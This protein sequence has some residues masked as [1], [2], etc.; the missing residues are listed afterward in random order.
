[1]EELTF[2]EWLVEKGYVTEESQIIYE[3][4]A[5]EVDELYKI[6]EEETGHTLFY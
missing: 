1:M 6:W 5:Y 2:N 4:C 3:L